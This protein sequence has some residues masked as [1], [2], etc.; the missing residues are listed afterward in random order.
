LP[1]LIHTINLLQLNGIREASRAI[2]L[3]LW[4]GNDH[5]RLRAL[6]I[7]DG[8][9]QNAGE[10]FQKTFSD[11]KLVDGLERCLKSSNSV[12]RSKCSGLMRGWLKYDAGIAR[13]YKVRGIFV[14]D[15][16]YTYTLIEFPRHGCCLVIKPWSV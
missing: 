16:S 6:T 3:E 10:I 1:I 15:K 12:V 7:L 9:I 14:T 4:Y 2:R 11:D 13:A 8:L 5:H